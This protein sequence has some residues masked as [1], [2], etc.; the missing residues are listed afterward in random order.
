[1]QK[2][3]LIGGIFALSLAMVGLTANAKPVFKV[4]SFNKLKG[5]ASSTP[6]LIATTTPSFDP[7]CIKGAV[8][9]RDNAIIAALDVYSASTKTALEARRDALK[10]AWDITVAKDRR[11]AIKNV[12]NNYS[13]A[14]REARKKL[15]SA[16]KSAWKQFNTD[17]KSCGKEATTDDRTGE[18]IDAQL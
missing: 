1:M 2:R 4:P 14:Q 17:S 11:L 10:A 13:K 6:S 8:E 5:N 18:G 12:W 7:S 3:F 16:Q 9:K 15:R